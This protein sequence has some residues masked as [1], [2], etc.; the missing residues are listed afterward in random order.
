MIPGSFWWNISMQLHNLDKTSRSNKN[1]NADATTVRKAVRDFTICPMNVALLRNSGVG[2]TVEKIL[3]FPNPN[4][5][6]DTLSK[7]EQLL[8]SWMALAASSGVE[9]KGHKYKGNI[10]KHT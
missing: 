2:N 10:D 8:S 9:V 5:D 1:P 6:A 3:K 7:L 4:I